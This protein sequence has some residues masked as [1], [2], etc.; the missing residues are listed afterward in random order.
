LAKVL[1]YYR[2]LKVLNLENHNLRNIPW[3]SSVVANQV[4][5]GDNYISKLPSVSANSALRKIHLDQNLITDLGDLPASKTITVASLEGNPIA[6]QDRKPDCKF[7]Y[8]GGDAQS[9][10]EEDETDPFSCSELANQQC[11]SER[12]TDGLQRF[13]ALR[14]H[15]TK[16]CTEKTKEVTGQILR[17]HHVECR[18]EDFLIRE[19]KRSPC[20][21]GS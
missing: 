1:P 3:L 16:L 18:N 14:S 10:C 8:F 12:R 17:N 9:D 15:W 4:E 21:T 13:H 7:C 2:G 11:L 6:R 5:L 20:F 19:S